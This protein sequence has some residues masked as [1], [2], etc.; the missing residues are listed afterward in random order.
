MYAPP[1]FC[2]NGGMEPK[3]FWNTY[4]PG[5]GPADFM[6]AFDVPDPGQCVS[7]YV[8]QRP[9]FYGIVRQRT[10]KDTFAAGGV[11]HTREVVRGA[12]ASYLEET[13]EE[14]EP[15][16]NEARARR[17]EER[18][19]RAEEA[20]R[21]RD[22]AAARAAAAKAA[23]EAAAAARAAEE[24]AEP[25]AQEDAAGIDTAGTEPEAPQPDGN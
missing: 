2:Y 7:E 4:M 5:M 22:E 20:A 13:R 15:V 9:S 21:A 18:R 8:R 6:A 25:P 23:E 3:D 16:A 10:W 1:G 11:Q 24:T 12:L 17:I 14:W 19:R